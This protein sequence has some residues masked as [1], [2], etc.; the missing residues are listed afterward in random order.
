VDRVTLDL[1]RARQAAHALLD[2]ALH[3]AQVVQGLAVMR[4]TRHL[5]GAEI[6]AAHPFAPVALKSPVSVALYG[7]RD[8][9]FIGIDADETAMA[10]VG[11]F[12]AAI[13]EAF[14]DLAA[15]ANE[16]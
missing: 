2:T 6:L 3:P 14:L 4:S 11:F 8:R 7:Y 16:A 9:L 1:E 5:A 10:D 15:T 13:V 12:E